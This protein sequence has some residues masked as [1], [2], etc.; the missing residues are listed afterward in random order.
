VRREAAKEVFEDTQ[1]FA[2]FGKRLEGGG[3]E[4]AAEDGDN[5][6]IVIDDVVGQA[7]DTESGQALEVTAKGLFVA[8]GGTWNGEAILKDKAYLRA[9]LE[10]ATDAL[11]PLG[12]RGG[13]GLTEP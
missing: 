7:G 1:E 3:D 12:G 10:V 11:P 9:S 6:L 2:V 4:S 5:L 13:C 8:P